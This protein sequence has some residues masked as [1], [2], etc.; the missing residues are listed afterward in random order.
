MPRNLSAEITADASDY[1]STVELAA[2]RTDNLGDQ[3]SQA[4]GRVERLGDKSSTTATSVGALGATVTSTSAAMSSLSLATSASLVPALATLSATA[5]PLTATL[6]GLATAAGGLAAGFGAVVGTGIVAYQEQLKEENSSLAEELQPVRE[7]LHETALNIGEE[8]VPL[9][10]DA[11][12]AMPA[13][14]REIEDAIGPLDPFAAALRDA[15]EAAFETIP[16][17][18]ELMMDMGRDALPAVRDFGGYLADNAVPI[19]EEMGET[20]GEVIDIFPDLTDEIING[21]AAANEFGVEVLDAVVPAL[22]V[23][24]SRIE[25]VASR[26]NDLSSAQKQ[27][28]AK[29]ALTA[30]ALGAVA[31]RLGAINPILGGV[32]AAVG[33]L[34]FAWVENIGDI[35]GKTDEFVRSV[36]GFEDVQDVL[37]TTADTATRAFDDMGTTLNQFATGQWA[38]GFDTVEET[39]SEASD[40]IATTLVGSGGSGGLTATVA[41]GITNAQTW[42]QT[43]GTTAMTEGFDAM[44]G[45]A[46]DAAM[47]FKTILIGPGGTSGVLSAMVDNA[48]RYMSD[49]APQLLGADAE[50]VG[51]A[52]RAGLIDFTNPLKGKNSK[53]WGMLTDSVTWLVANIPQ[54]F[55]AVGEGIVS[56]I[57]E[58]VTGLYEGLVGNSVMKDEIKEAAETAITKMPQWMAGV[59]AAIT[60][61]IVG[62][63]TGL[64]GKLGDKIEQGID[65]A[66]ERVKRSFNTVNNSGSP[67]NATEEERDRLIEDEPFG[68]NEQITL[69][70]PG[71][72]VVF[73][74]KAKNAPD[75]FDIEVGDGGGGSDDRSARVSVSRAREMLN[76]AGLDGGDYTFTGPTTSRG[77]VRSLIESAKRR[78][79]GGSS[80]GTPSGNTPSVPDDAV[81][82]VSD[83]IDDVQEGVRDFIPG[84][85]SGGYIA[86]G[87]LLRAHAGE[88]VVPPSQV[89]DRGEMELDPETIAEGV[90]RGVQ[91]ANM[92]GGEQEITIELRD[93]S[94]YET[95][96]R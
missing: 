42:L 62:G 26:F 64:A 92:D 12:D 22:P 52:I 85:A 76:N 25:M 73:Q 15:G 82:D 6:G 58:G 41:T 87:G 29:A 47:D 90:A 54:L 40:S 21:T 31:T 14:I 66:T 23:A 18:V 10:E 2:D 69:R 39:A 4:A 60:S 89:S 96:R 11:I 74:G 35:R 91:R 53:I 43:D 7:Q 81:D 65:T 94:R 17:V 34:G 72:G 37:Q 49:T 86:E 1:V 56:A 8:F 3:A 44:V 45:G 70:R 36:S 88:R 83:V 28:T 24:G 16:R 50:N 75:R 38:A 77:M 79:G 63:V 93:N 59:G 84:L 95:A 27:T 48:D 20:T 80:G 13:F 51:S 61:A 46:A 55:G 78:P 19:M 32:T 5:V 9:I 71:K 68:P 30:P 33:A 67:E 57:V